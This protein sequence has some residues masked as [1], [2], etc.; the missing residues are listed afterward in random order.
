MR[1]EKK[2]KKRNTEEEEKEGNNEIKTK[3]MQKTVR[4]KE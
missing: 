4:V 2:K 3:Y 1:T